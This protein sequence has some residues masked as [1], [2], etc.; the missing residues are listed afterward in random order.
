MTEILKIDLKNKDSFIFTNIN[1]LFFKIKINL[2]N[3]LN[4]IYKT[5]LNHECHK[6]IM[7]FLLEQNLANVTKNLI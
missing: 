2:K 3:I 1:E 6:L 4:S 7:N 5:M